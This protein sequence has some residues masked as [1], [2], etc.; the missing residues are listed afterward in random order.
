[1]VKL[2][3]GGVIVRID[4]AYF[5]PSEVDT[6][7]GDPSKAVK[8]LGWKPKVAFKELVK[9]MIFADLKAARKTMYL[10]NGGF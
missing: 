1:M 5:R 2:K 6:L 3:K 8:K 10:K 7:L 9:E 4:P